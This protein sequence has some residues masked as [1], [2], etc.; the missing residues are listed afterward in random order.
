[1]K[2]AAE[3]LQDGRAV[4][5]GFARADLSTAVH[6][7]GHV[8]RR[9]L[10]RTATEARPEHQPQ[11]LADLRSAEEWCGVQNGVWTRDAEERFA[12]GF[13]RYTRDGRAPTPGLQRLFEQFR[14]WMRTLY[15]H[16]HGSGLEQRIHPEMR[17]V[18]DRLLRPTAPPARVGNRPI[19]R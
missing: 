12:R 17:G 11:L 3:F 16:L 5:R 8:F 6:E 18:Y 2:G 15:Q 13:E 9:D 7:F 4:L 10:Q 1:V 14:D 19:P